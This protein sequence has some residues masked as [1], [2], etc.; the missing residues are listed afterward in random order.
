M[1]EPFIMLFSPLYEKMWQRVKHMS[2][3]N[4]NIVT[5]ALPLVNLL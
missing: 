3:L 2:L 1:V 4:L 5:K